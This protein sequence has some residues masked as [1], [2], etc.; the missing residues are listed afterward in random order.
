[1]LSFTDRAS[2]GQTQRVQQ[3]DIRA[4]SSRTWTAHRSM[5]GPV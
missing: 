3:S 2:A 4:A 1:M 5:I